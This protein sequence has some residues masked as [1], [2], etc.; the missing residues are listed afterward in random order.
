M[1]WSAQLNGGMEYMLNTF[2][3]WGEMMNGHTYPMIALRMAHN[4]DSTSRNRHAAIYGY[5]AYGFEVSWRGIG[6]MDYTGKSHLSDITTMAAFFERD[7]VRTQ[8]FSA[9]YTM[10]VGLGFNSAVFDS[11]DNPQNDVFSAAVLIFI[12]AGLQASYRPSE[13]WEIGLGARVG[14]FSAGRLSYPNKGLNEVGANLSLRYR[15]KPIQAWGPRPHFEPQRRLFGEIYAGGGLHR[16]KNEWNAFGRTSPWAIAS[17]GGSVNYRILDHISTGLSLDYFNV[18]RD[19]LNR[20]EAADRILQGDEKVDKEGRY[21]RNSG[22]VSFLGQFNYGNF[23]FITSLGC[24]VY[25]H[26]G[27]GDDHGLLY[28]RAGVKY[29]MPQ[30]GNLFLAVNV[31][32]HY[33]SRAY[34]MEFTTGFRL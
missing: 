24:Y 17:M 19:F 16:C 1:N 25:R 20:L 26:H 13:H 3:S 11:I 7:F 9:G 8:H 29:V 10:Q 27:L 34:F 32:S 33:F 21:E 5:P 18:S 12:G 6:R 2:D 15:Q 31:Y 30:L 22:G 23:S 4:T 28:Q 14:H